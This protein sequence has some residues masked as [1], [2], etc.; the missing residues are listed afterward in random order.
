[1]DACY[2][3]PHDKMGRKRKK[4]EVWVVFGQKW[5]KWIKMDKTAQNIPKRDKSGL[6]RKK[7]EKRGNYIPLWT[8]PLEKSKSNPVSLGHC[9]TF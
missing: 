6:N 4:K 8:G 1:M 2:A 5:K 9:L 3:K 7:E